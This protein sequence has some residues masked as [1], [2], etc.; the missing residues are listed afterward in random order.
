M[1]HQRAACSGRALAAVALVGT[2]A[3]CR[4][5]RVTAPDAGALYA[6]VSALQLSVTPAAPASPRPAGASVRFAV[7]NPLPRAVAVWGFLPCVLLVEYRDAASGAILQPAGGQNCV[8][9]YEAL[10]IPA[11]DSVVGAAAWLAG[12]APGGTLPAPPTGALQARLV[13]QGA[14]DLTSYQ[15]VRVESGWTAAFAVTPE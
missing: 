2:L 13:V 12:A 6:D 10:R 15:A 14:T 1:S 3:G 5:D 7:H 8:G 11:R 4:G 9:R